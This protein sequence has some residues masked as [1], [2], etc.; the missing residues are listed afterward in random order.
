MPT[1]DWKID[2]SHSGAHFSVRHLVVAKVRGRFSKFEGTI[3]L[4][5]GA[6]EK[7]KVS[8]TIDAASIDTHE[9]K[10]DD[11]LRSPDFFDVAK[12]P[13]LT[14]VSSNIVKAGERY[15]V[16]GALTIHGVTREVVLDTELLGTGKDPWGGKRA[17]FAAKTQINRKDFGLTW[18]QALETGGVVVGEKVE[19]ELEVEAVAAAVAKVA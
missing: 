11:H 15:N 5:E 8:V 16:H 3:Q 1:Q 13:T 17:G 6:F 14:F 2:P 19:I 4:D 18:N 12:F 10:R 9:P 7:S